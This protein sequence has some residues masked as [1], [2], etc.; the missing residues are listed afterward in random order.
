MK[1]LLFLFIALGFITTLK[2]QYVNIIDYGASTS[3]KDNYVQ[4]Q[5]AIDLNPNKTIFIPSGTFRIKKPLKIKTPIEIIGEGHRSSIIQPIN[6]NGI[7]I[8]SSRVSLRNLFVYGYSDNTIEYTGIYCGNITGNKKISDLNFDSIKLQNIHTGIQ[9]NFVWNSVLNNVVTKV[10][11][12][13]HPIIDQAIKFYGQSVNNQISNSNLQTIR[14]GEFNTLNDF[15]NSSPS[16]GGIGISIIRA[17]KPDQQNMRIQ[18]LKGPR[19]EGLMITNTFI[20]RARIGVYSEGVLSLNIS[21]S[22]ID[23]ITQ[24]AIKAI[25]T[26]GL[27]LTNNWIST[28]LK[29]NLN[30]PIIRLV[31]SQHAHISN[32]NIHYSNNK[33]I[34]LSTKNNIG[35]SFEEY[36]NSCTVIGNTFKNVEFKTLNSTNA[37]DN[38][39]V[40]NTF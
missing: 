37:K 2:A 15:K 8:T 30:E 13:Q 3:L 21:N 28:V 40:Y 22:T 4:I 34:K 14:K 12:S 17:R 18:E 19:S 1:K 6:C 24:S 38:I 32:N 26:H 33:K 5:K 16:I 11:S 23:L 25:K 35:V 20:G 39:E 29:E 9:L 7:I 10:N 27:L 36:T 31:E